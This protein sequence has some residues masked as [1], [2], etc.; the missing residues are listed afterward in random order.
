MAA[1]DLRRYK[2]VMAPMVGQSELAFRQFCRRYAC[3]LCYS[4]MVW[5]E[6]Y[7]NELEYRDEAFQTCETD[8]PLIIQ[9]CG[10]KP[11]MLLQA[12]LLLQD[13]CDGIDINLGCPQNIAKQYHFGSYLTDDKDWP[14][15][16]DI[17]RLLAS[18]LR[19]P[20]S[21]KIRK[22]SSVA[23]TIRFA[24]MLERAGAKMLGI[25]GRTREQQRFGRADWDLIRQLKQSLQI[26]VIANGNIHTFTDV[27][28]CLQATGADAV[29]SA[30][31]L[32]ANPALFSGT[33]PNSLS[34]AREYVDCAQ[35]YSTP[36]KCIRQHVANMLVEYLAPH[37]RSYL[38]SA[39]RATKHGDLW[40]RLGQCSGV[41]DV[42]QCISEL[43]HRISTGEVPVVLPVAD[44]ADILD[45]V[46][47]LW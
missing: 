19:V 8:R 22:L 39:S 30:E 34:L 37:R 38:H 32:L 31:A 27:A 24:Q 28:A 25:H 23:K 3:E 20:L 13:A 1:L 41:D 44:S 40:D 18:N 36:V 12:A 2:Y 5:S 42:L 21:V 11:D 16:E 47:G 45:S 10:N 43:E 29:M 15:V 26:P 9:L 7:V 6:R 35:Q 33:C 14:L 46:A 17:V 4:P